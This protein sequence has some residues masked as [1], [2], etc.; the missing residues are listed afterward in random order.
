MYRRR[1]D[2]HALMAQCDDRMQQDDADLLLCDEEMQPLPA[3]HPRGELTAFPP[4]WNDAPDDLDD[5]LD[6]PVYSPDSH[7]IDSL[8][9]NSDMDSEAAAM[10]MSAMHTWIC[11]FFLRICA[12]VD[13]RSA[14]P[15][16]PG[17]HQ[18]VD[19]VG[20]PIY[21][22][23]L[24]VLC[25]HG[26]QSAVVGSLKRCW[27]KL[28]RERGW[29]FCG[30]FVV[31]D[32]LDCHCFPENFSPGQL[33]FSDDSGDAEMGMAALRWFEDEGGKACWYYVVGNNFFIR[34]VSYPGVQV[35][36][37]DAKYRSSE[38][39][40]ILVRWY[41]EGQRATLVDPMDDFPYMDENFRRGFMLV[42]RGRAA[43]RLT[44]FWR[45]AVSGAVA[46]TPP[47]SSRRIAKAFLDHFPRVERVRGMT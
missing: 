4:E 19:I 35:L 44:R 32:E 24:E 8:V 7:A 11:N 33:D 40:D 6:P 5:V 14:T 2:A 45:R 31:D 42:V 39:G 21:L 36:R 29:D 23:A 20:T 30:G 16:A 27:R 17:W 26:V 13:E 25:V 28:Q 37:I 22:R 18:T 15:V 9:K 12:G 41:N 10:V 46:G 3:A 47:T 38:D 34:L 43:V 1:V